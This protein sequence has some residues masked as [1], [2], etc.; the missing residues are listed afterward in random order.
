MRPGPVPER[1]PPPLAREAPT[2]PQEPAPAEAAEP[3]TEVA[4]PA[5]PPTSQPESEHRPV[6]RPRPIKEKERPAPPRADLGELIASVQAAFERRGL[7]TGDLEAIPEARGAVAAWR[8]AVQAGTLP[9]AS[10]AAAALLEVLNATPVDGDLVRRKLE[11]VALR[12]GELSRVAPKK[13]VDP[14]EERYLELAE[15]HSRVLSPS[16]EVKIAIE[17]ER[18]LRDVATVERRQKGASGSR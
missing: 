2:E 10:Q 13:D 11:R 17:A 5:P 4:P 1:P 16:G 15:R 14:L 3:T 6:Q 8:A 9:A 7:S 18:L 12:L